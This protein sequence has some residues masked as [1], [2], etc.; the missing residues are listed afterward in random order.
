MQGMVQ[1]RQHAVMSEGS[2]GHPADSVSDLIVRQWVVR[3]CMHVNAK[4]CD[5]VSA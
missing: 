2:A 4:S 1:L 5:C 3:G